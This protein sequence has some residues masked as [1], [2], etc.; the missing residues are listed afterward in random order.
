MNTLFETNT[1]IEQYSGKKFQYKFLKVF[2]YFNK[3]LICD[4]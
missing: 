2:I 1:L 3:M 4:N